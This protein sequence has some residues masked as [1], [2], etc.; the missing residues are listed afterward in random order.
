MNILIT[1]ANGYLAKFFIKELFS[2]TKHDLTLL[3]RK[4]SNVDD[5]LKYVDIKNIIFYDG[6]IKSLNVL[7]NNKTDLIF[8]L[9]NYYPDANR[10]AIPEEIIS[11]NLTLIANVIS[12]IRDGNNCRIINID[13]YV[14]IG[15]QYSLYG[16]TKQAAERYISAHNGESYI[17]YDT[18]GA[19]DPRPK[20]INHLINYSKTGKKLKMKHSK[21]SQINLVYI[22]DVISAFMLA[23]DKKQHLTCKISTETLTLKKVIDTFNEV[24]EKKVNVMWPEDNCNYLPVIPEEVKKPKG[25]EQRYNLIMGL[26]EML[27]S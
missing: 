27:K 18:Y 13:S 17:L 14:T 26:T 21:D 24:S 16:L 3:V 7:Q 12:S 19:N 9:A 25:W 1:G 22:K 23:I 2:N 15:R 10:P 11:S 20:L 6:N 4:D 8:H 5:L